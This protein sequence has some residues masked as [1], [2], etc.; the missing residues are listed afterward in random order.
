MILLHHHMHYYREKG[1]RRDQTKTEAAA[2]PSVSSL[3][4]TG[5]AVRKEINLAGRLF[6]FPLFTF[7]VLFT[8]VA[9]SA[10]T[11]LAEMTTME[12]TTTKI[13]E[14]KNDVSISSE[15]SAAL[16]SDGS[17][18]LQLISNES[19]EKEDM[20]ATLLTKVCYSNMKMPTQLIFTT[21]HF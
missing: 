15:Q 14:R 17:G 4:H 13:T 2:S 18:D 10:P 6:T 9:A 21:R 16:Y 11:V 20:M 7:A 3:N 12:S 5:K 8:I 19:K 1:K